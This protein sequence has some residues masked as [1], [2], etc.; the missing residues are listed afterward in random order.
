MPDKSKNPRKAPTRSGGVATVHAIVEATRIL[1]QRERGTDT[2]TV[3]KIAKVA[4]VS[5]ASVYQFFPT[6]EAVIAA[7]MEAEL[8]RKAEAFAHEAL[9]MHAARVPLD[10]AVPALTVQSLRMIR[11]LFR[12][13]P[14]PRDMA[15][16]SVRETLY[17]R[18][19]ELLQGMLLVRAEDDPRVRGKDIATLA[20]VVARAVTD[21]GESAVDDD[22]ATFETFARETSRM[23]TRYVLTPD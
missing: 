18:S 11:E 12:D 8:G 5:V 1:V 14:L 17:A 10:E 19:A 22:D 21:L 13:M 3:A 23:I 4:G 2:V 16:M 20:R 7:C 15:R 9:A 6:K